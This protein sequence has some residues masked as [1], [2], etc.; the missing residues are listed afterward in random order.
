MTKTQYYV[1]ASLDGYIA[2]A[3][4][5][6]EWLFPFDKVQGVREHYERFIEDVS[7]LAMGSATYRFMFEQGVEWPYAD[8]PTWVFTHREQLAIPGAN[9]HFTQDDVGAVHA[10]MRAAAN[11]KNIWLVGGGALATQFAGRGLIDELWLAT[12]PVVLG[13]GAPLFQG[14]LLAPMIILGVDHFEDRALSTRY[15]LAPTAA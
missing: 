14:P 3:D 10:A 13:A 7:V 6:L 15:R 4:G 2:D 12:I 5:K 11:G 9:L 8:K 1:A